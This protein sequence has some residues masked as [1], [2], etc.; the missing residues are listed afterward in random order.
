MGLH[1][2]FQM[3]VHVQDEIDQ[4]GEELHG[5]GLSLPERIRAPWPATP[6]QLDSAPI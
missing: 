4:K 6:L 5:Q 3:L 1:V 2:G